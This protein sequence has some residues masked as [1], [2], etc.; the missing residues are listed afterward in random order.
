MT[1]QCH[2][3]DNILSA[4]CD[5]S[6]CFLTLIFI[7]K[8]GSVSCALLSFFFYMKLACPLHGRCLHNCHYHRHSQCSQLQTSPLSCLWDME[9][10]ACGISSQLFHPV[11]SGTIPLSGIM[12]DITGKHSW[13]CLVMKGHSPV[14]WSDQAWILKEIFWYSA[15]KGSLKMKKKKPKNNPR[16]RK[17]QKWRN[18]K[19]K[20]K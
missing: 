12:L 18:R 13:L 4:L 3:V 9:N 14:P 1:L 15:A 6:G 2:K 17:M 5:L 16:V 11:G 7:L 19:K 20:T 8:K 10:F